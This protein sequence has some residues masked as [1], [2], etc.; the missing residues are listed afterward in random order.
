MQGQLLEEMS[1]FTKIGVA[2]PRYQIQNNFQVRN[3]TG[4]LPPPHQAWFLWIQTSGQADWR[5]QSYTGALFKL[6]Y[7]KHQKNQLQKQV[8]KRNISIS[9]LKETL[10]FCPV[11]TENCSR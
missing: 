2:T 1:K 7:R 6:Q 4:K 5:S 3:L 10:H 11:N 9:I 8:L